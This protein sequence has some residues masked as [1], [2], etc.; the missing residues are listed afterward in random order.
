[1]LLVKCPGSVLPSNSAGR[2]T[3]NAYI[4]P[5][6]LTRNKCINGN[7]AMIIFHK[8][9]HVST[10]I[11]KPISLKGPNH[12]S[13]FQKASTAC[14]QCSSLN[15]DEQLEPSENVQHS[16]PSATICESAI[17]I[18]DGTIKVNSMNA[19]M[20]PATSTTTCQHSACKH[21]PANTFQF[22]IKGILAKPILLAILPDLP[23]LDIPLISLGANTDAILNCFGLSDQLLLC[24]HKLVRTIYNIY[25]KVMLV[26]MLWNLTYKQASNLSKALLVDFQGKSFD[27]TVRFI[28]Y[29]MALTN[30]ITSYYTEALCQY[31][32]SPPCLSPIYWNCHLVAC[33]LYIY[34]CFYN[35]ID[36]S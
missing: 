24:L 20:N 6:E 2:F 10:A 17:L 15:P 22:I 8:L 9:A 30:M 18:P 1:M 23:A 7:M 29:N 11:V 31:H 16:S 14:I 28:S 3:V 5:H 19:T 36:L 21:H 34:S 35:H 33:A 25:W 32:V 12:V 13:F 26:A 4:T 27:Q